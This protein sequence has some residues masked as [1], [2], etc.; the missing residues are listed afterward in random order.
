MKTTTPQ[1]AQ[2]ERAALLV[3][4][5]AWSIYFMTVY[6]LIEAACGIGLLREAAEALILIGMLPTLAVIIYAAWQGRSVQKQPDR[7]EIEAREEINPAHMK[8]FSGQVGLWLSGV[9]VLLT[10]AVGVTALVL[11]PC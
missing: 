11:P 2:K 9:F 6:L 5:I 4:P 8:E 3:S 1:Q 7:R 10:L